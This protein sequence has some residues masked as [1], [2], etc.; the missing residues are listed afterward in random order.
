[1]LRINTIESG[2]YDR[3][4]SLPKHM[5]PLPLA[6][7]DE[8]AIANLASTGRYYEPTL[9]ALPSDWLRR[10]YDVW[11][12]ADKDALMMAELLP[13]ECQHSYSI[14]Y[15]EFNCGAEYIGYTMRHVMQRLDEH[16]GRFADDPTYRMK[17]MR[18]IRD[19]LRTCIPKACVLETGIP[20]KSAA[21][22]MEQ[23]YIRILRKPLNENHPTVAWV[24]CCRRSLRRGKVT[25]PLVQRPVH[26]YDNAPDGP[27]LGGTP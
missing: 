8:A 1:M 27:F 24:P 20:T 5:N 26:R 6:P 21:K 10:L 22:D 11:Q 25:P 4:K 12:R 3:Y 2:R 16:R 17:Q 19:E 18:N 15:I 9:K 14:Y 7:K 13:G 23:E